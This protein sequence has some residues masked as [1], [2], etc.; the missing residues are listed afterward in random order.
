MEFFP[1]G[2]D[3]IP[4]TWETEI[5]SII[6][7]RIYVPNDYYQTYTR[8]RIGNVV[9]RHPLM[10][11]ILVTLEEWS[12]RRTYSYDPNPQKEKNNHP[13]FKDIILGVVK[14]LVQSL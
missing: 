7:K 6:E 14:S 11:P 4:M 9:R 10:P 12:E 5:S 13:P 8:E 1:E 2:I 3:V